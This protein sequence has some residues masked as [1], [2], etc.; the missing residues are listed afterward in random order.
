MIT[1]DGRCSCCGS[2]AVTS[3]GCIAC[4]SVRTSC[5]CGALLICGC[6]RS[7]GA[8][9]CPDVLPVSA[10]WIPDR[11]HGGARG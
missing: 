1:L 6:G 4:N 8:H 2:S 5:T 3:G 9:V 11:G 10:V 7:Q